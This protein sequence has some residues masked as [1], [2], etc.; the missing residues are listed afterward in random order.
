MTTPIKM[1]RTRR[2]PGM[3]EIIAGIQ[4]RLQGV[5]SMTLR[6]RVHCH[7]PPR[8]AHPAA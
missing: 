6:G 3:R 1:S 7:A 4:R 2:G 8:T 5:P